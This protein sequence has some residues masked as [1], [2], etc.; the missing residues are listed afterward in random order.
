MERGAQTNRIRAQLRDELHR[1]LVS[2]FKASGRNSVHALDV[3]VHSP[4]LSLG[5]INS[6]LF[7]RR[8]ASSST[9]DIRPDC[10][11]GRRA[12]QAEALS[13]RLQCAS[14]FLRL[15]QLERLL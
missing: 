11:S 6:S 15:Y 1:L 4:N 5:S 13:R 7:T 14:V 2:L 10:K 8:S 9:P 12:L 3:G